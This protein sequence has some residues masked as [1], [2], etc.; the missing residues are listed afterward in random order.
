MIVFGPAGGR[1]KAKSGWDPEARLKTRGLG[2]GTS[3]SRG[4][5][6]GKANA[7]TKKRKAWNGLK[8]KR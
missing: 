5:E 7:L 4:V 3:H 8:T 6:A 1:F 2:C